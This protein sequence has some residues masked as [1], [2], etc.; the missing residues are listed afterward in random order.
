MI[1]QINI[2]LD[3]KQYFIDG[4]KFRNKLDIIDTYNNRY[5]GRASIAYTKPKQIE[6]LKQPKS[7]R[8]YFLKQQSSIRS[9]VRGIIYID[10]YSRPT[11]ISLGLAYSLTDI[12]FTFTLYSIYTFLFSLKSQ[13]IDTRYTVQYVNNSQIIYSLIKQYN[14][15]V[16]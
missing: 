11:I 14:Q 1:K 13:L 7:T 10:L 6:I 12:P 4:N 8:T 3:K 5:P 16:L 15:Q 2:N 9:I